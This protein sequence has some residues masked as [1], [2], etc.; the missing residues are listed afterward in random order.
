MLLSPGGRKSNKKQ[1]VKSKDGLTDEVKED[2]WQTRVQC[3][4]R[5][6]K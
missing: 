1:I 5:S 3:L 4:L 2:G 6:I